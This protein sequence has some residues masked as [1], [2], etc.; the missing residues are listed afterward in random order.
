[1][2]SFFY[3]EEHF[4][5]KEAV[6]QAAGVF[7]DKTPEGLTARFDL[8]DREKMDEFKKAMETKSFFG[9]KKL[10]LVTNSFI[11][12]NISAAIRELMIRYEKEIG[13]EWELVFYECD[14]RSNLEK[15]DQEL[16]DF[17]RRKAG[18]IKELAALRGIALEKWIIQQ[19]RQFGLK[20]SPEMVRKL[21]VLLPQ[22]TPERLSR[23]MEK[24]A[25]YQ[26]YSGSGN[27]RLTDEEVE[28]LVK[29]EIVF[30]NFDLIDAIALKDK[31]RAVELLYH[32]LEKGEEPQAILGLMVYQFRNLLRIKS[33]IK[34]AISP[35]RWPQLTGL[36]PFVI[37]KTREQ[38][39]RFELEELK[40]IYQRLLTL[41]ISSKNGQTDLNQSL[42]IFLAEM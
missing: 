27:R 2:F 26:N 20:I 4:L 36:H 12:K 35:N 1:M 31:R 15:K 3:G 11:S 42:Y 29:R 10:A 13:K 30:G 17:L 41:D 5:I 24:L 33:L 39:R 34:K 8:Q 38:V 18:T 28:K 9:E 21:I 25:A 14:G 16:F 6:R 32:F 22:A 7:L 19:S 23:E 40:K 37:K